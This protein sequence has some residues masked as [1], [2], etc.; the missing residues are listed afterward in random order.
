[1]CFVLINPQSWNQTKWASLQVADQNVFRP[2]WLKR[3]YR[4][5]LHSPKWHQN[6]MFNKLCSQNSAN[7]RKKP[8]SVYMLQVMLKPLSAVSVPDQFFL[9]RI[10]QRCQFSCTISLTIKWDGFKVRCNIVL[11][12]KESF[13]I[14]MELLAYLVLKS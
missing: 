5:E 7:G 9:T 3:K 13:L 14:I 4:V 2:F 11:L 6:G 1:M 12:R 8:I 10:S